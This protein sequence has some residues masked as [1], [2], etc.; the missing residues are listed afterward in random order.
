MVRINISVSE[1]FLLKVDKYKGIKNVN[2]SKFFIDA[3]ENY[4]RIIDDELDFNNRIKAMESL[5]KTREE[6]KKYFKDK[7]IDVVEEIKKIREDRM[8]RIGEAVIGKTN[9]VK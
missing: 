8:L 9:G 4:F 5:F 2:R 1:D 7:N 6:L 3:A